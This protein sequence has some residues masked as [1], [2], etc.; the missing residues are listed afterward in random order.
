MVGPTGSLLYNNSGTPTGT[1]N[2]T[3]DSSG[4]LTMAGNLSVGG[5]AIITNTL[6]ALT[7]LIVEGGAKFYD[8]IQIPA[9]NLT[10]Q[11]EVDVFGN[12]DAIGPFSS[13]DSSSFTGPIIFPFTGL[14]QC[15]HVDA[16]GTVS[17]TGVDCGSGSGGVT[18]F[19]AGNLSPLFTTSVA[20]ASTTPALS[21]SLSNAAQNSVLAGPA[22][23]GAGA[24]SYQTAPTISAANM[25][26]FPT[27]NQNTTGSAGSVPFSGVTASTNT[28][29]LVEG[30]GG[31][32]SPSGT[33]TITATLHEFAAT[34]STGGTTTNLLVVYDGITGNVTTSPVASAGSVG[35][36][37]TTATSGNPL[38]VIDSGVSNCVADNTVTVGDLL[39][40]GTTTAGRCKDLGTAQGNGVPSNLQIVGKALTGGVAGTTISNQTV[41]A[42]HYGTLVVAASVNTSVCSNNGCPQT[43][44]LATGIAGGT[45]NSIPYQSAANTTAFLAQ[46]TGVLYEAANAP[47]WLGLQ[48][49]D[50]KV[51]T[52]GTVSG[53]GASLCTDA[54]GGATTSGCTSGVT[55]TIAAGTAAL[56]TSP[57]ASGACASVV[58]GT[59]VSGS[60]ANI[61]STDVIKT[62]FNGDPTGVTGYAPATT[63]SLTIYPYPVAATSAS[64]KVCNPTALSIT[65]GALTLNWTVQR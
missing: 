26:N 12:L 18:T 37:S 8:G 27:F 47:T 31:S 56:G 9:G 19:S 44:A 4:D 22:S 33:G 60:A 7:N 23:G 25:T 62:G 54:N 51:L 36:A 39:G 6:E 34:A 41:G 24:P 58:T 14:T 13:T 17:G 15:L 46:G 52:S 16:G 65:P 57:I 50:S 53:T 20:N 11:D 3:A 5:T 48:G 29:A 61:L 2:L 40:V 63:G 21:F 28:A 42:G 35:F 64:F 10:V 38:F 1:S 43:A 45:T 59:V 49:T 55:Y 32:I 30:S